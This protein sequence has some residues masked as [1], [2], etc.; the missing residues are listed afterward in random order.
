MDRSVRGW[1][2]AAATPDV[3]V[4]PQGCKAAC[5]GPYDGMW[6]KTMMGYD[7]EDAAFVLELT[8]T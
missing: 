7:S 5:N 8:Y 6:S 3:V 1:R 2:A 4:L